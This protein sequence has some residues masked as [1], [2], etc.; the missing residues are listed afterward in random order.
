VPVRAVVELNGGIAAELGIREGDRLLHP[1]FGPPAG[2]E[3]ED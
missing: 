2:G 1:L 3:V